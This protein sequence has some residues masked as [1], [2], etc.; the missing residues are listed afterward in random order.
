MLTIVCGEDSISSFNYYSS[1]KQSYLEKEYEIT[2]ISS[3]DLDNITSWMGESQSL[4]ASKQVFFTQNVNKKLSKKLNLKINKVIEDLIKNK[5]IELFSWEEETSLRFLK[6][7]KGAV[8]KE[9]KP[10]ESIFKLQDSL[11]PG[12]LKGF[13]ELLFR[14]E[15]SVDENFI[16]IMLI[17]HLRNL[18]LVKTNQSDTKL[19]KWQIYKLKNQAAKWDADNLINFYNSLYKIE[20]NQK[21]STNPYSVKKSIDILACYY[22]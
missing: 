7:P 18:I 15:K 19:Q 4:F 1:L 10:S 2:N 12:N 13:L 20:V 21:T 9:F 3:A 11:F 14:L 16:F 22:L 17:R 8:I 6:F 5:K